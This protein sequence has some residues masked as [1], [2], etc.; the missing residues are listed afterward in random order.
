QECG[1]PQVISVLQDITLPDEG[2]VL[3]GRERRLIDFAELEPEQ[4]DPLLALSRTAR[5]LVEGVANFPILPDKVTDLVA[6]ASET[7]VAVKDAPLFGWLQDREM[8]RLPMDVD[9]QGSD[10]VQ[11]RQGREPAVDPAR[12]TAAGLDLPA[13]DQ[14]LRW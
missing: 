10:R 5:D 7:C 1:L 2:F 11:L 8:V 9:Q 13:E 6:L 12:G 3:A 14:H 4:V